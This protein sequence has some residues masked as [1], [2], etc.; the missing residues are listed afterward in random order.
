[1]AEGC[2]G[3]IYRKYDIPRAIYEMRLTLDPKFDSLKSDLGLG[4][5]KDWPG[6]KNACLLGEIGRGKL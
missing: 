6:K 4:S 2:E 5:Y 1:M 3:P